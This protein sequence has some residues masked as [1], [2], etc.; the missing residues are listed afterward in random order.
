MCSSDLDG[1]ASAGPSASL[2]LGRA[3][4]F[5]GA[6]SSGPLDP[7]RRPT[8]GAPVEPTATWESARRLRPSAPEQPRGSP[9]L[10]YRSAG[11]RLPPI[12]DLGTQRTNLQSS[13]PKS[14]RAPPTSGCWELG[15]PTP[16]QPPLE[17]TP[18]HPHPAA[19]AARETPSLCSFWSLPGPPVP[20]RAPRGH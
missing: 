19:L 7:N 11:S 20:G 12:A 5:P 2:C 10:W 17:Y 3:S 9:P 16:R 13:N 6:G 18:P 4:P 1:Q 14:L 8:G 15:D